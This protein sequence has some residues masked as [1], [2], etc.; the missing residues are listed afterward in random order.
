MYLVGTI[1]EIGQTQTFGAKGFRRRDIV[2]ETEDTYPQSIT[3]EFHQD[4]CDALNSVKTGDRKKISI[5]ILGKEYTDKAGQLRRF[6]SIKG[7]KIDNADQAVTAA[8]FSP[9]REDDL[10]Y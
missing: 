9:D 2:L 5:N 7:W 8:A 3:I 4:G 6:N 1:K 10:P